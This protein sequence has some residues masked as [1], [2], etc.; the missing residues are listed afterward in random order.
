MRDSSF[1]FTSRDNMIRYINRARVQVAKESACLTALVTGQ[2]AFGTSAQPGY[3]IPGATIPGTLPGS[4][5][6]NQNSAGAASTTQNSFTTIPGV[7]LYPYSYANPYLRAQYSGYS[8]V[9]YV[10]DI[11]CSWG[12]FMPPLVWRPWDQLQSIYRSYNMGVTSY[13][14]I[15][16]QMMV[17]ENGQIWL[18]PIPSTLNPG[19]MEWQCVCTPINLYSDDDPE[20]LPGIYQ[21]AV[22]YY[23]CYI[24]Y[25]SQQRTGMADVM[26]GQYQERLQ[27]A[28]VSGDWGHS[29]ASV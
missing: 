13:P 9:I 4:D 12:G 1:Q 21:D 16:S 10:S 5:P 15:W 2:S 24:A 26:K 25:L 8:N 27:I 18:F 11:S 6:N 20:A 3:A 7:E 19:A 17:G 29:P 23:A 14:C 28:G 22:Q